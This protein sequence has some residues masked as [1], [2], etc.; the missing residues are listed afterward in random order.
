MKRIILLGALALMAVATLWAQPRYDRS[1]LKTE[2]LNRGVVAVRNGG[3]VIISWRTLSSDAVGEAFQVY[4][5]G[6]KLT[7][8]PLKKGGTFFIDEQPSSSAATYEVRGGKVNGTY[9]LAAGAPDGYLPIPIQK[10]ADGVSPDGFRYSFIASDA[11]IGDVDGDGQYEIFLKW[12]PTNGKDNMFAGF[13]GNTYIDCYR[14]DGTRLWR[15][16]LGQNIRSGAHFEQFMVFDFDGDGR[17]ELMM[18]TADGTVDGQGK[19]IGDPHADWRY[20]IAAIKADPEAYLRKIQQDREDAR[21]RQ[22]EWAEIEKTLPP[23]LTRTEIHNRRRSFL[24]ANDDNKT[25]RIMDGPEYITVFNGLT[26]AAMATANYIPER[27]EMEAWGD[28]HANRSERYL[29]AVGYLDGV[30]ASGIFCRGYYTRTVIAAWDWDGKQLKN[31]WTFDTK[32]PQWASY[33]GRC[34][35]RRM[36][37]DYLWCHGR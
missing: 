29:A 14:L 1:K 9:T 7:R 30:H 27:G 34:R 4:R 19:V 22:Q 12:D 17:A 20:G 21:R 37:R 10:P 16:D 2:R 5:D 23:T 6:V 26:G 15:I 32:E 35:W 36:R 25:G 33:A 18:K 13:T 11:S 28:D 31:R 8:K 24:N 3:K